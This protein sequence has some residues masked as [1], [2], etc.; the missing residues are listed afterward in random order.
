MVGKP[1]VAP[2][3]IPNLQ[4]KL[5]SGL[6]SACS[7][8]GPPSWKMTC[9]ARTCLWQTGACCRT[10]FSPAGWRKTTPV[11]DKCVFDCFQRV[12]KP[13][14][15][16]RPTILICS[17]QLDE[18]SLLPFWLS[19]PPIARR[20][21]HISSNPLVLLV[22]FHTTVPPILPPPSLPTVLLS[23]LPTISSILSR[24]PSSPSTF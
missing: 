11:E 1:L 12:R 18:S 10:T 20:L 21:C 3:Q 17:F 9:Q 15:S 5:G 14:G 19:G 6:A 22:A 13:L 4:P 23:Y 7:R 2:Q 8:Q 24:R 16:A